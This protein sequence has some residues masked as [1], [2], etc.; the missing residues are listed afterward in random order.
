RVRFRSV[1]DHKNQGIIRFGVAHC[2]YRTDDWPV[3]R[4]PTCGKGHADEDRPYKSR[5]SV[6]E[7]YFSVFHQEIK[8]KHSSDDQ[9]E[10]Y[11]QYGSQLPDQIRMFNQNAA[12]ERCSKRSEERRVGKE[13]RSQWWRDQCIK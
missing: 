4:R 7:L 9:T 5:G 6:F 12:Q 13:G 11:D 1:Y 10:Y 2:K 8:I 3:A